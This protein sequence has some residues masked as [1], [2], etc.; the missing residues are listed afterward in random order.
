MPQNYW[1]P[2]TKHNNLKDIVFERDSYTCVLCENAAVDAHHVLHKSQGGRD[3]PQNLVSICRLHHMML[4]GQVG[5]ATDREDAE[6]RILE[7]VSDY[8]AFFDYS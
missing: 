8:Y 5:D 4:H 7:Y 6:Q 3:I 2:R 1:K